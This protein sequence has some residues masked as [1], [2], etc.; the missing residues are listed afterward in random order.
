MGKKRIDLVVSDL[1][2]TLLSPDKT[3]YDD[4]KSVI[5]KLENKNIKF[6]FITGR[7][8]Y[9][10]ERFAKQVNITAPIITCNGAMIVDG[11]DIQTKENA[12]IKM[13][14]ISDLLTEAKEKDLTVL[15]LG[16]NTEYA[17]SE[18]EWTDFRKKAGRAYPILNLSEIL[19]IENAIYKLNIMAG[20]K[21]EIFEKLIPQIE[22][23]KN[24]YSISIYGTTGCEIVANGINK[25]SALKE[26]CCS[27]N[28][29]LENVLAIGDNENDLGMLKSAGIGAAV[30]NASNSAKNMADYICKE[31][32]AN[33]VI[34]A[35]NTFCQG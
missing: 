30:A 25:E 3:I 9:A 21:N 16:K 6:T 19:K 12:K 35:I 1:D 23:L 32:Y 27:I 5:E 24:E 14:S 13:E 22:Y 34:E 29:N 4:A 15:V 18:T 2:D 31:S 28:I 11:K 33:G 7:P 26:L 10:V 17:L 8:P 20:G